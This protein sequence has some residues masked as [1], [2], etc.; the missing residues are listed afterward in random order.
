MIEKHCH[1]GGGLCPDAGITS[2]RITGRRRGEGTWNA[3]RELSM[4]YSL[5]GLL[6]A[7]ALLS[8]CAGLQT[9]NTAEEEFKTGL[10][11]FNRGRF[12]KAVPRFE[13]ATEI[14]P[15]FARAYLYLGRSLMSLGRWEEAVPPLRAA[16]RMAPDDMKKE[17]GDVL[18]DLML[19]YATTMDPGTKRELEQLLR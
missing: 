7:A 10:S 17:A 9:K 11:L 15:E 13:R 4:K 3:R 19:R 1:A 8:S 16:F 12:E 18:L 14:D 2:A 6:I 5:A